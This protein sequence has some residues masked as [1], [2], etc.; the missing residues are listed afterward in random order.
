MNVRPYQVRTHIKVLRIISKTTEIEYIFSEPVEENV[1]VKETQSL[2]KKLGKKKNQKK[3]GEKP[4]NKME[5]TEIHMQ[6]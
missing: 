2:E 5:N 3:Y 6:L 4:K 1:R